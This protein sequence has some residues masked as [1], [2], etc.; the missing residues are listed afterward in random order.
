LHEEET[1]HDVQDVQQPISPP[2]DKP[3]FSSGLNAPPTPLN[4]SAQQK[5]IGISLSVGTP[6]EQTSVA[7][8]NSSSVRMTISNLYGRQTFKDRFFIYSP[9]KTE[10]EDLF[11]DASKKA[12]TDNF[13]VHVDPD[14]DKLIFSTS[15]TKTPMLIR[16]IDIFP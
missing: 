15:N 13:T 14:Q 6:K 3:K 8:R 9:Y 7:F 16:A 12:I 1:F 11:T 2:P 10:P 4:T 5:P